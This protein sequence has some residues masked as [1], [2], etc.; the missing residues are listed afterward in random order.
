[1]DTHTLLELRGRAA[2]AAVDGVVITDP[3][4]PDNPIVDVNPAFERMTGYAAA[5]AIGRNCRFLQGPGTDPVARR[6]LRDALAAGRDCLVTLLN[7]RKDGTPFWNELRVAPV[8]D[9]AGRITHFVGIQNDVTD[10]RVVEERTAILAEAS[11]ALVGCL[12]VGTALESVARLTAPRLADWSFVDIYHPGPSGEDDQILRRRRVAIAHA[13][14]ALVRRAWLAVGDGP[15]AVAPTI[16][17]A[18]VFP[19]VDEEVV[20]IL[21]GGAADSA[22]LRELG[23]ASALVAPLVVRDRPRGLLMLATAESGRRLVAA[24]LATVEALARVVA[25]AVENAQLF[26]ET[27]AAL[28]DRDQFLSIAAHELRTP[29]TGVKGYAQMLLRAQ[30]RGTLAPERLTQALQTIDRATSRL[31]ALTDDLLDVS[32]L[33]LGELPLQRQRRS[34][35]PIVREVVARA[36]EGKGLARSPS[37][38]VEPGLPPVPVDAERIEQVLSNLVENAAKHSPADGPIRIT[39]RGNEGGVVVEV[40]DEGI[41]LPAGAEAVIF[42]PFGRAANALARRL[43]GLGLGLHLCRSIVERHGGRIWARSAGEG[44]GTTVGFWLPT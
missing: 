41:G 13:D 20:A 25:L 8:R 31:A 2:A 12:D 14:P 23:L 9:D 4:R 19:R 28:R 39:L 35:E 1:M 34:L 27:Q 24:E 40:A 6:E 43:P 33:R 36:V 30:E 32:R 29:I 7:Y 18:R 10:R 37:I 11:A 5:E 16:D 15:V 3:T 44:R 26:W 38:A 22:W 21:A 42:E 17:R